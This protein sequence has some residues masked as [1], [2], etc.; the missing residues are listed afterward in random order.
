MNRRIT[1]SVPF[2]LPIAIVIYLEPDYNFFNDLFYYQLAN[3]SKRIE[4]LAFF[5]FNSEIEQGF[6]S[7]FRTIFEFLQY[8]LS[9]NNPSLLLVV[10]SWIVISIMYG[11]MSF[12][13]KQEIILGKSNRTL[14]ILSTMAWPWT[15][16]LFLYPGT[17]EKFLLIALLINIYFI[18]S[19][20]VIESRNSLWVLFFFFFILLGVLFR[21]QFLTFIPALLYLLYSK[22]ATRNRNSLLLILVPLLII[23]FFLLYLFLNGEYTSKSYFSKSYYFAVFTEVSSYLPNLIFIFTLCLLLLMHFTIFVKFRKSIYF[24]NLNFWF[25]LISCYSIPLLM[26]GKLGYHLSILGLLFSIYFLLGFHVFFRELTLQNKIVT[27]LLTLLFS[28]VLLFSGFKLV[29]T[30]NPASSLRDFFNSQIANELN[31][32]SSTIYLNCVEGAER[33]PIFAD[34]YLKPNNIK[35]Y[36]YDSKHHFVADGTDSFIL[37]NST[38]CPLPNELQR[39]LQTSWSSPKFNSYTLYKLPIKNG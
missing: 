6:F 31:Y 14:F 33:I 17:V 20:Y 16:D 37:G 36:Q 34:R 8:S 30:L 24:P 7:P 29:Y 25:L 22:G 23:I 3:S 27:P 13:P 1:V 26:W 19:R 5:I 39:K 11:F 28:L 10:N 35:F 9:F 15:L 12:V 4:D 21:I 2:L 18:N 38:F 32:S